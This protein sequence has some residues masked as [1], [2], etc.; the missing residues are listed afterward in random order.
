MK[1]EEIIEYALSLPNTY[2]DYPFPEDRFSC[3][4]ET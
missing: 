3:N 4:N 1:K 2:E